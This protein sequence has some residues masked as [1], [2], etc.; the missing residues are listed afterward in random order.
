MVEIARNLQNHFAA[1]DTRAHT[2]SVHTDFSDK[3]ADN[4]IFLI[5]NDENLQSFKTYEACLK[6]AFNWK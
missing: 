1:V 5:D 6:Y 3:S 2:F 4:L